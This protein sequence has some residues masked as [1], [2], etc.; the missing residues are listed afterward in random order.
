M[1]K[2]SWP[3]RVEL[4]RSSAVVILVIF[5]CGLYSFGYDLLWQ[6]VFVFIGVRGM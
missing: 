4:I 3:S 2:V 6:R 1:N 5:L